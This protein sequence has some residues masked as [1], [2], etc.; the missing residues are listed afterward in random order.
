MVVSRKSAG[1]FG[2]RDGAV[3]PRPRLVPGA[4]GLV[5]RREE[6]GMDAH[7]RSGHGKAPDLL[8]RGSSAEQ[9]AVPLS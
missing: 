8:N 2:F 6:R 1:A 5:R 9:G 4:W 7:P 3:E